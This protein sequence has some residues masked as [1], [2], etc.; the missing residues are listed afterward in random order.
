MPYFSFLIKSP[1]SKDLIDFS[2]FTSTKI[3]VGTKY[4]SKNTRLW[5]IL[6]Q[7]KN[8]KICDLLQRENRNKNT[9]FTRVIEAWYNWYKIYKGFLR[10]CFYQKLRK[11]KLEKIIF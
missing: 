10:K 5:K 6:N 11:E 8:S 7:K 2:K 9:K 4:Y 3:K 1:P